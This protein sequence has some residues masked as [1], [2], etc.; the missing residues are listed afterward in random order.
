MRILL[1]FLSFASLFLATQLHAENWQSDHYILSS[2]NKIALNGNKIKKWQAPIY[3]RIKHHI[4][5]IALHEKLVSTHMYQL[6]QITGLKIRPADPFHKA[7]LTIVLTNE[8]QF[9]GDIKN[10]FKLNNPNTIRAISGNN[11]GA[12]SIN[13]TRDGVI[14]Q[15]TVIIPTDRARA[16]GRLLTTFAEMLTKAVGMQYQSVDVFPSIF[17]YRATDRYL[18]GLDYVMLKL[19]YDKRIKPGMNSQRI[20]Q[21]IPSIIKEKTYQHY[22]NEASL[23]VKQNGLN[24]LVN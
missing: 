7:N 18:T 8:Q 13:A 24:T 19:L 2:F 4:G 1:S 11:I 9:R 6:Q 15:S 23:S 16:Y 5:D 22:I 21:L 17:N 12:T 14:K 20:H 10:H 3:Y